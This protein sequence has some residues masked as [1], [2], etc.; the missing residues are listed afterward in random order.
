[1]KNVLVDLHESTTHNTETFV[2]AL[3]LDETKGDKIV[4][5]SPLKATVELILSR[6][7]YQKLQSLLSDFITA[8]VKD[9]T[10]SETLVP[11]QV[12]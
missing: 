4:K 9:A 6:D 2:D 10:E 8:E 3:Q 11:E 5:S 1:M 7:T 12:A